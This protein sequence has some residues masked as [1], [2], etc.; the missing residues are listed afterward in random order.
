L[1]E[2]MIAIKPVRDSRP[3]PSRCARWYPQKARKVRAVA[4]LGP[5]QARLA[6]DHVALARAIAR[7]LK[8]NN[9]RFRDE[10]ESAAMMALVEAAGKYRTP[11]PVRFAT[12]ARHIITYRLADFWEG[13]RPRGFRGRDGS[14]PATFTAGNFRVRARPGDS[15]HSAD[16]IKW[17]EE[18][19]ECQDHRNDLETLVERDAIETILGRLPRKHAA[20]LRLMTLEDLTQQEAADRLGCSQGNVNRLLRQSRQLLGGIPCSS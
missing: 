12:Y 3:R 13:E 7:P 8:A 10:I 15:D 5:D 11:S 16:D 1:E 2:L 19:I 14:A 4:P 17:I 9:P 20:P 6:A 18:G